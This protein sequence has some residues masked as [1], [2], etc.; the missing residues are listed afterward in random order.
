MLS[1]ARLTLSSELQFALDMDEE[2][3]IKKI[4]RALPK[5]EPQED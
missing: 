2:A 3:V 5:V 1:K 4:D